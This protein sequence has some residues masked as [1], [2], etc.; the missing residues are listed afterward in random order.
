MRLP[1]V[2][3][4]R[5]TPRA[6]DPNRPTPCRLATEGR[7]ALDGAP[8][9]SAGLSHSPRPSDRAIHPARAGRMLSHGDRGRALPVPPASSRSREQRSSRAAFWA[10]PRASETAS[11][12]PVAPGGKLALAAGHRGPPSPSPRQG[13]WLFDPGRLPPDER[14]RVRRLLQSRTIHEHGRESVGPRAGTP[15]LPSCLT[16]RAAPPLTRPCR[17][18]FLGSG[19]SDAASA[20]PHPPPGVPGGLTPKPICASTPVARSWHGRLDRPT[21]P[22][23]Q[24]PLQGAEAPSYRDEPAL[25]LA[26]RRAG[27]P[28]LARRACR[29]AGSTGSSAKRSPVSP[30]PGCFRTKGTPCLPP[31]LLHRLLPTCGWI[32]SLAVRVARRLRDVK[33]KKTGTGGPSRGRR[34]VRR[35]VRAGGA[36]RIPIDLCVRIR[37]RGSTFGNRRIIAS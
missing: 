36:R 2:C 17:P 23:H 34:A 18:R 20:T 12:T 7:G 35:G 29:E 28:P 25:P 8:P 1:D 6:P 11:D 22:R 14:S 3:T 16:V 5:P 24:V 37:F 10:A 21:L 19:E 26:Q 9:A 31:V 33:A 30:S 27:G 15:R 32:T 13:G 4:N